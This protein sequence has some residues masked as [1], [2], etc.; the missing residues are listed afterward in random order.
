MIAV[1]TPFKEPAKVAKFVPIFSPEAGIEDCSTASKDSKPNRPLWSWK[2]RIHPS[3]TPH[4]LDRVTGSRKA[5][6]DPVW[7]AGSLKWD[8]LL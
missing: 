3:R 5:A 8:F 6:R 7:E 2:D 1:D 4:I